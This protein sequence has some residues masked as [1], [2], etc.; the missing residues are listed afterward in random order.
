MQHVIPGLIFWQ[1]REDFILSSTHKSKFPAAQV[2]L[3][4]FPQ[5][6]FCKRKSKGKNKL[7]PTLNTDT[8]QPSGFTLEDPQTG[9]PV[10]S[11]A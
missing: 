4:A 5:C 6:H 2:I 11:R 3:R 7:D 8:N 1:T 9:G 10:T